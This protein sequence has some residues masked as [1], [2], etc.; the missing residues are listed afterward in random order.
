MHDRPDFPGARTD[1]A[2]GDVASRDVLVSLGLTA[3]RWL[4][5]SQGYDSSDNGSGREIDWLRVIP[6]ILMHVAC[7]AVI[8]VGWSPTA[9]ATA[10]ALYVLRMLAITGFYHR[11]FSHKA[12]KTSRP[13]QFLF[14]V[15]GASA[16][17]RGPLWWASHHRHHHANSD[18]EGDAHSPKQHGF[19][20][21]HICWFLTRENYETRKELV[22]DLAKYPELRFLDRYDQL[23]PAVLAIALF[24]TGSVLERVAPALGVTGP[25]LLVWG[26][27]ISTVVLYHATFTVNSLAHRVGRRRYATRDDSRNNFLLAL[28]TLGEGWHNNHHHY[29]GSARQ[30]FFW[31]EVDLTYYF[32]RLLAA[33]GVISDLKPV[34]AVMRNARRIDSRSGRDRREV[35]TT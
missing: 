16:V 1:H 29:P 9:V 25:Q 32:L 12:F 13:V 35:P 30:G 10:V 18:R 21:S 14:A 33:I 22:R 3:R 20:W 26:F 5:S 23:V 19:I 7:F 17:Q 24:V 8:W 28:L 27:A 2:A 31:W 34:P 4:D 11:Y 6:F 15:L